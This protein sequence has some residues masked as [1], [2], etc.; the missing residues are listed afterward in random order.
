MGTARAARWYVD[1]LDLRVA[2]GALLLLS[3]C[4]TSTS[5]VSSS[6]SPAATS[7][8][9]RDVAQ[10]DAALEHFAAAFN[11]G[12]PATIRRALSPELWALSFNVLGR[13]DVAYGRDSAVE[14]LVARRSDGDVLEFRHAQVNELS[15]WDGAAQI[16]PVQFALRRGQ[17][18]VLLDGKGALYCGGPAM[19]IKVLGLGD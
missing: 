5:T 1:V 15:G 10:V 18:L 8:A 3:A 16:G 11:S 19:G 6:P 17:T 14:H 12:D 7:S 2:L 13:D 4:A 9:C